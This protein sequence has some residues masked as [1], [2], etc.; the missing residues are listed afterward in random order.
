MFL[1]T[2]PFRDLDRLSRRVF[3]D[4]DRPA[5]MAMDSFRTADDVVVEID[6]PGVDRD[7]IDLTVEKNVLSVS[8][9]RPRSGDDDVDRLLEER[10]H[11][12]FRRRVFLGD[13]L[14]SDG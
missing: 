8:A 2:D 14:D 9:E 5:L 11:G 4:L 10:G 12:V 6:L 7:S 1:R 13:A 3:D